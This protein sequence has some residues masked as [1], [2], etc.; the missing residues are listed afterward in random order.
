MVFKLAP[1]PRNTGADSSKLITQVVEGVRFI[2]GE[3][4]KAA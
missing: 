4:E 1:T 2:D 3:M